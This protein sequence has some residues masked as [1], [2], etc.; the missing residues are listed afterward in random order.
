MQPQVLGGVGKL[1]LW[2]H[3]TYSGPKEAS[4]REGARSRCT[5]MADKTDSL[6]PRSS[7]PPTAQYTSHIVPWHCPPATCPW[8]SMSG[9]LFFEIISSLTKIYL[10]EGTDTFFFLSVWQMYNL[11]NFQ[12]SGFTFICMLFKSQCHSN[13]GKKITR[14][15]GLY[16]TFLPFSKPL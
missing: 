16:D 11:L 5:Q 4:G 2:G 15:K 12:N 10:E 14:T 13:K 7:E 1:G 9:L 8:I 3:G 6:S